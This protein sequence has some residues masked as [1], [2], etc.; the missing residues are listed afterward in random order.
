[1]SVTEDLADGHLDM[2]LEHVLSMETDQPFK[3]NGIISRFHWVLGA[4]KHN[5]LNEENTPKPTL[6]IYAYCSERGK[7]FDG[8][9][10]TSRIRIVVESERKTQHFYFEN[11]RFPLASTCSTTASR[12]ECVLTLTNGTIGIELPWDKLINE[13]Q[14]YSDND[15]LKISAKVHLLEQIGYGTLFQM[16]SRF[17]IKDKIIPFNKHH[18]A[19]YSSYFRTLFFST[20]AQDDVEEHDLTSSG[21]DTEAF[22]QMLAMSYPIENYPEPTADKYD[23]PIVTER[24]EK[25]LI[26]E[27]G[28]GDGYVGTSPPI[29]AKE[30]CNI[31]HYVCNSTN[32][33]N[34][35]VGHN[36]NNNYN[37]HNYHSDN[38]NSN[39][40]NIEHFSLIRKLALAER[41]NLFNLRT[42]C[43]EKITPAHFCADLAAN[44]IVYNQ[45]LSDGLKNE[46]QKVLK[47]KSIESLSTIQQRQENSQNECHLPPPHKRVRPRPKTPP[48]PNYNLP[49]FRFK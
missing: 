7:R 20:W 17:R 22:E 4:F 24:C 39:N 6:L 19:M 26:C 48:R 47:E 33:S 38:N 27:F 49:P 43:L 29:N 46:L 35:N 32:S 2:Q 14:L 1:M 5:I 36:N 10:C 42:F 13:F 25:L 8:W 23:L 34:G 9:T 45:Q 28:I 12:D 21:D 41:Y 44:S 16:N 11:V 3:S 40:N 37:T 15:W 31:C 18:L 30:V